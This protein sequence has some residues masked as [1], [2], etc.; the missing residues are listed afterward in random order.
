[1]MKTRTLG[2]D[3]VVSAVGLG[4]MGFSHAYGPATD[5]HEAA[6]LLREAYDMGYRFFDTAEVYG[7]PGRIAASCAACFCVIPRSFRSN[8]IMRLNS[9]AMIS[10]RPC[11]GV[12]CDAPSAGA[13]YGHARNCSTCCTLYLCKNIL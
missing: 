5:E 6:K 11:P 1:M 10:C 9:I 2:R 8:V 12:S 7:T 3:L 4:C 13:Q